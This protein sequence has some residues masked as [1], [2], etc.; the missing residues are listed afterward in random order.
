MPIQWN[1]E[2]MYIVRIIKTSLLLCLPT[3]I[4][5]QLACKC[6][7]QTGGL[8]K[9][10]YNKISKTWPC[11]DPKDQPGVATLKK[12]ITQL[13]KDAGL[14]AAVSGDSTIRTP[15]SSTKKAST[16]APKLPTKRAA[17]R[18]KTPASK[19]RKIGLTKRKHETD[20]SDIV[21]LTSSDEDVNLNE[22]TDDEVDEGIEVTPRADHRR[23]LPARSRKTNGKSYAEESDTESKDAGARS[24]SDGD[25]DFDPSREMDP[26]ED[27]KA[28]NV[29]QK[30]NTFAARL[31][32]VQGLDDEEEEVNIDTGDDAKSVAASATSF[33]SA[34]QALEDE[35]EDD[36]DGY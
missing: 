28:S 8:S 13:R 2:S 16:S 17:P 19:K 6:I 4:L 1:K 29:P 9:L 23:V 14:T 31:A 11:D 12:Q 32:N 25:D 10:D 36:D 15:E 5:S 21:D 26:T 20:D 22:T 30:K 3:D 18:P 7:E 33:K 34:L 27:R 24:D 35:E